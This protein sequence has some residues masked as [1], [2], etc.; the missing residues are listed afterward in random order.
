MIP[1]HTSC[2][3]I[4]LFIIWGFGS[5]R[6][7]TSDLDSTAYKVKIDTNSY[8]LQLDH[9]TSNY[10]PA[11]QYLP[12]WKG[13]ESFAFLNRKANEIKIYTMASGQ[14]ADSIKF[15]YDGPNGVGRIYDFFIHNEDS[16]FL[17]ARYAYRLSLVDR[18]AGLV[19]NY[20][21]VPE[22]TELGPGGIPKDARTAL[23]RMTIAHPPVLIDQHLFIHSSPDRNPMKAEYYE[24]EELIIKL[25]LLSGNYHYLTGFPESYKEKAWGVGFQEYFW[26]YHPDQQSFL[27]S[28]PIDDNIYTT[29]DFTRF[30]T[31]PLSSQQI[32]QV[33]PLS[34]S[35]MNPDVYF[36]R[37][38]TNSSY[39]KILF[40]SNKR[41]YY[42]LANLKIEEESYEE[43]TNA[44]T[45]P[46]DII[47]LFANDLIQT[48]YETRIRQPKN[49]QFIP[50]FSFV[51]ENGLHIGYIDF[52]E[53]D[54][55][56]FAHIDLIPF[57]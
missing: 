54:Q 42:R 25:D 51:N 21:L 16:I 53:E 19:K 38:K 40:D 27:M 35:N 28:F 55:L 41:Y 30:E 37:Y 45:N 20:R 12:D 11:S 23:G 46:Q 1:K 48:I 39:G 50:T 56:T 18:N 14:V 44:L 2:V 31:Y 22:N 29:T 24:S 13:K 52:A 6:Q 15:A 26:S 8:V 4:L 7:P 36:K 32:S 17:H 49:G 10:E 9:S 3:P 5:C 43:H 57:R 33:A 34:D 47:V